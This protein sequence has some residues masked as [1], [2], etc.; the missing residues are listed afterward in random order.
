MAKVDDYVLEGALARLAQ[1]THL[2]LCSSLPANY[3]AVAAAT[4]GVKE[5]PVFSSFS[6]GTPSG[7]KVVCEG[8]DDGEITANGTASHYVLVDEVNERL[9]GGKALA[10]NRTVVLGDAFELDAFDALTMLDAT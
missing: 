5:D 9:L 6:D 10:A 7:R 1:A 4:L 3:A 2:Y 8:F